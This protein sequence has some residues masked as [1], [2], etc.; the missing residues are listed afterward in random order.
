MPE[1]PEVENLRRGLVKTVKGQTVKSVLIR[2]P[3]LVSGRG[4]MRKASA[5]AVRQFIRGVAGRK[6][7]GVERRGKNLIIVLSG[8]GRVVV[9]LKMSGGFRY[10]PGG[11]WGKSGSET[12]AGRRRRQSKQAEALLPGKHDH[13][14]FRLS[15]GTLIYND[16]RKFG[17]LIYYPGASAAESH[18]A[19]IGVEPLSQEFTPLYLDK[20]LKKKHSR[21]KTVLMSQS[22]VAGLGNIYCDEALFLAGV[23]PMRRASALKPAEMKK[24]HR[25]IRQVLSRAIKLGGSTVFTYRTMEGKRG[26]YADER[27]VYGRAG[28]ECRRCGARLIGIRINNRA[29]TYCPKCQR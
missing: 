15:K 29:T 22:V 26:R 3:K 20:A 10:H 27:W 2:W 16:T 4:S 9:H 14:I 6:I 17:Y 7:A 5:A 23:R 21:I 19:G 1:L 18:F 11:K 24:L 13:I 8:G 28:D 25:V 12:S